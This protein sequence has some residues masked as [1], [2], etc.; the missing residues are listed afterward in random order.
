MNSATPLTTLGKALAINQNPQI[1]GTFAEIGAGQEVARFFFHAGMASQ[2]IAKTISAY[3]MIYSD[4]IYGKEPN[5]RYVCENR[6]KKMLDKEFSLLHRRLDSHRGSKTS[7]FAFAN[8]VATGDQKKR[9]SHGWMGIRFQKVP[10]GPSNDIVVH[11]RLMDKYRLQQQEVLGI[12]GVNLVYMAFNSIEQPEN[13]IPLLVDNIRQGQV[14]VDMIRFDGPD[15]AHINNHLINLELVH[16]G[17]SE[18]ILFGPEQNILSISDTLYG[19]PIV[20]QRGTF[21]PVTN[22]HL[23][24]LTKGGYQFEKDFQADSQDSLTLFELTMSSLQKDGHVNSADFLD[25]VKSLCLLGGHVL[26]SSFY[27]FYKLKKFLRQYT[28][29]PIA[30]IAG[31]SHLPKMFAEADYTDLEGGILEGM[32]KLLDPQTRLYIYPHKSKKDM[33]TASSFQ[34]PEKLA[35]IYKHFLDQGMITHIEGSEQIEEFVFSDQVREWI[36]EKNPKW[37]K[38]V[39]NKIKELINNENLFDLKT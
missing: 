31:A 19:K 18:G 2:T 5:G 23:E 16:R 4:E 35:F 30:I 6:V 17:L 3:D 9:Y 29:K 12:I 33:V 22:T 26:V 34:P 14:S 21:R 28:S 25:R 39:P 10:G 36:Q 8:T 7:F 27:P 11:I 15:V 24:V 1:Y 37:E 32:G 20:L 13:L 38:C